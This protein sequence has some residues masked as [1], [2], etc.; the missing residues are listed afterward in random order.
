MS[1]S[2]T[3]GFLGTIKYMDKV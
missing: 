3:L 2:N 1:S